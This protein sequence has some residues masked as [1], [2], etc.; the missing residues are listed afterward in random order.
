MDVYKKSLE[1]HKEKKGKLE[2]KSKV[3]LED[4]EDLSLAYTPGVAEPCKEIA[5]DVSKVYDYTIKQNSVAVV[6]D[7][8]AVLGLG[9]I[10]AEASIPVMEGKCILM[11]EF[12][13]IDAF[14]ICVRTQDSKKIIEI[15]KNISPVFGGINL[16]DISAPRC[17][18]I[19][20]ELQE[21]GI[22]VFHDDQHGT[23]IVV[24]AGLVNAL[25]VVEKKVGDI[26]VV[27]NGAGAAGIAI[28]KMLYGYGVKEIIIV[29]SKGIVSRKRED[30]NESKKKILEITNKKEIY[31]GLK[32]AIKDSD[33]FVGVS[34]PNVVTK[35]MV[36]SMNERAIIFALS[37][38][39]PEIMPDL[40][41][42]GGAEVVGT[43]RSDFPNQ[44]NNVLAF[45]GIFRGALDSKAKKITE[46]MK[47]AA[48]NAL[49]K[50]VENPSKGKILP[51]PL[52]KNVSRVI[53]EAVKLKAIEQGI[54][55]E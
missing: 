40:A 42:E 19:E 33:V 54:V 39:I 4:K 6:S 15:V 43:G 34:A 12:G 21:I 9:N 10:G 20:N 37:N 48:V 18:E 7:G 2:I 32:E 16:E 30:L 44:I 24:M 51:S 8:S 46:G 29:D 35:E 45:P 13:D 22:P 5:K 25:K 28:T 49:A 55:R 17:F 41:Y 11:K 52:D 1:M 36:E 38:P 50:C 31:G 3:K 26:K 53:A 23:A 14:P 47:Y 27:V